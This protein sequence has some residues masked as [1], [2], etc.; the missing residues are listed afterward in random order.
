MTDLAGS[1]EI[2]PMEEKHLEEVLKIEEQSFP[3]PWTRHSYFGELTRNKVAHYF[4][5]MYENKVIG[6]V[7]LWIIIDEAHITTIAVH[8]EYRGNKVAKKLIEFAVEYS[9]KWGAEKLALEV[10]E[11]NYSAKKLYESMGFKE[12]GLRENYYNDLKEDAII[13]LKRFNFTI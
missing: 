7:G 13:M 2:K 10:R 6:Y 4:V 12:I 9:K 1:L 3:T 11:S 8:P 5:C